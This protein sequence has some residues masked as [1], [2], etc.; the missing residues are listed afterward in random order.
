MS[1]LLERPGAYAFLQA[2]RLLRLGCGGEATVEAFF[3]ERLRLRPEL[4]LSFPAADLAALETV[5]EQGRSWYQLTTTFLGLYGVSSP[6]P[7]HYTE[8][9]F[10]EQ[11]RDRRVTRDFLDIL[12]QSLYWL[13]FA[14]YSRHRW[15]LRVCEDQDVATIERLNCLLGRLG[16]SWQSPPAGETSPLPPLRHLGLFAQFPRSALGLR[17]LVADVLNH[18]DVEIVSCLHRRVPIAEPARC[19]L[20]VQGALLGVSCYVG[21]EMDDRMGKI[22]ICIGSLNRAKLLNLLPEGKTHRMMRALVRSYLDQPIEVEVEL[23]TTG[24][25]IHTAILGVGRWG[26]LGSNTWVFS[27]PVCP[28]EA[29]VRYD[30]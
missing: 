18:A 26:T 9:L 1:D 24:D 16:D 15:H 4:S 30:L 21:S 14:L 5:E 13:L 17:T 20:G 11:G 29:F 25:A 23:R 19:Y 3:N 28:G 12:Q 27:G 10:E 8:E 7:T 6:L 2:V 22:C